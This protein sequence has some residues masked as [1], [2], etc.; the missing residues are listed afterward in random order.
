MCLHCE[1][2]YEREAYISVCPASAREVWKGF[3][4]E[5][6]AELLQ[7]FETPKFIFS[8]GKKKKNLRPKQRKKFVVALCFSNIYFHLT[9]QDYVPKPIA[10]LFVCKCAFS[11]KLEVLDK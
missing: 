9:C 1:R 8:F 6:T 2:C 3:I 10:H 5:V 4:Q 7:V 11:L